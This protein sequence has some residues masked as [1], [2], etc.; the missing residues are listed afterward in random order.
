VGKE[1]SIT[2]IIVYYDDGND[3]RVQGLVGDYPVDPD[4]RTWHR[5]FIRP[6]KDGSSQDWTLNSPC[7]WFAQYDPESDDPSFYEAEDE[8]DFALK[9]DQQKRLI[10]FNRSSNN[11]STTSS[12]TP[13]PGLGGVI[14]AWL[15]DP[16]TTSTSTSSTTLPG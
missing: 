9:V 6:K 8:I 12:T 10:L 3:G 15:D 14:V 13:S 5:F 7:G 16:S 11:S 2:Q 1:H 4:S